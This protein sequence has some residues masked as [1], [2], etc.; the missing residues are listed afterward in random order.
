MRNLKRIEKLEKKIYR[1]ENPLPFKYGDVVKIIYTYDVSNLKKA[2]YINN[3]I[4][5]VLDCWYDENNIQ[6][7]NFDCTNQDVGLCELIINNFYGDVIITPATQKELKDFN[8]LNLK[9]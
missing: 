8:N 4:V 9:Q 7:M 5:K 2:K 1:L 3:S 6:R